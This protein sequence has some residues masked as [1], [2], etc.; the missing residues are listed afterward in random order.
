MTSTPYDDVFK[1]MV[2]GPPA[3]LLSF[4]NEETKEEKITSYAYNTLIEMTKKVIE[5]YTAR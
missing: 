2:N 1:T 5:A 4:L 3:L